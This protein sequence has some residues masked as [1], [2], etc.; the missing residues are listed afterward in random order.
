M[1]AKQRWNGTAGNTGRLPRH[2]WPDLRPLNQ[3]W[4]ALVLCRIEILL[5]AI[6]QHQDIAVRLVLRIEGRDRSD[7]VK[8]AMVVKKYRVNWIGEGELAQ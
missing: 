8:D 4:A 7:A 3:A 6:R 1:L 2:R 5:P